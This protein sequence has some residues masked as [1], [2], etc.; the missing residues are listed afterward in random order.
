M[1]S[2]VRITP[3]FG[4]SVSTSSSLSGPFWSAAEN[5]RSRSAS[6]LQ[7]LITSS[8]T[9][10]GARLRSDRFTA[11]AVNRSIACGAAAT[12]AVSSQPLRA[13]ARI[14]LVFMSLTSEMERDSNDRAP[15]VEAADLEVDVVAEVSVLEGAEIADVAADTDVIAEVHGHAA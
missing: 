7:R 10:V 8:T 13:A 14:F 11:N 2:G 5:R 1:L 12:A 4:R 15:E 3:A 9:A 6:V